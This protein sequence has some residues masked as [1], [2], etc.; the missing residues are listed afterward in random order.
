MIP[1]PFAGFNAL[2]LAAAWWTKRRG[3]TDPWLSGT[4]L[5]LAAVALGFTAAFLTFEPLALRPWLIF[6]FVFL[7][8]LGVMALVLLDKAVAVAQLL[9]AVRTALLQIAWAAEIFVKGKYFE[10]D[11]ILIPMAILAGFNAFYL[12]AAWGQTPRPDRPLAL[13]RRSASP[14]SRSD[15]PPLS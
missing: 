9:A 4:A 6:G 3:R 12:V 10:G 15:S 5:G 2:Y 11:R 13:V 8:D 7:I 1:W 14:P